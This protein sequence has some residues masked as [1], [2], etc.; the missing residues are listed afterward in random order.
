MNELYFLAQIFLV[1]LFSYGALRLG[2]SSLIAAVAILGILANFFVLKQIR[3]LGFDITCSDAFAVGSMLCL[4]LLREYHGRDA[5]K[6]AINTCFFFMVFFVVMSGLHLRFVPSP[7]DTTHFAYAR[8]L[9]PA[10]RL[11]CSSL[12]VFYLSQQLDMR[13]FGLISRLLPKSPFP[14]RSTLSLSCSQLFDTLLFNFL[15]LFGLVAHL[16][17][18]II[19]SFLIKMAVTL[20]IGPLLT[21]FKRLERHA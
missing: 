18:I 6:K 1:G 20:S 16:F 13:L 4:N 9:T 7:F 5:G 15:G 17:D 19:I 2:K 11:L 3:F 8:L 14:L 10:P 12:I 21:L